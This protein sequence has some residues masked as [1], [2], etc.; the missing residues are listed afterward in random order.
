MCGFTEMMQRNATEPHEL[1]CGDGARGGDRCLRFRRTGFISSGSTSCFMFETGSQLK[2]GV[3]YLHEWVG[4]SIRGGTIN[5]IE[6]R[7]VRPRMESGV[8]AN[9]QVACWY[10][11]QFIK[12]SNHRRWAV[13]RPS[14]F[15][16]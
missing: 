2:R 4:S 14:F 9:K 13:H 1:Q 10:G 8:G 3:L 7:H 15:T 12:C 16:Q 5:E 11:G 6:G